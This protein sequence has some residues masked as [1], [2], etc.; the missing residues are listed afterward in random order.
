[1]NNRWLQN[2]STELQNFQNLQIGTRRQEVSLTRRHED[3][4]ARR[5]PRH[6][7]VRS[8]P[9]KS[10]INGFIDWLNLNKVWSLVKVAVAV[11]GLLFGTVSAAYGQIGGAYISKQAVGGTF[12]KSASLRLYIQAS[13]PDGGYVTYQWWRTQDTV[14]QAVVNSYANPLSNA[15]ILDIKT[16]YNAVAVADETEATLTNTTPSIKGNY[17]YWCELGNVT[18]T[19]TGYNASLPALVKIVDRTLPEKLMNGDFAETGDPSS[20]SWPWKITS[21]NYDAAAYAASAYTWSYWNTTAYNGVESWGGKYIALQY[22]TITSGN[23]PADGVTLARAIELSGQ[24]K[25]S[26]YQDVATVPGKIYEWS[27]YHSIS[28]TTLDVMAV[29]IG[30]GINASSDYTSTN[31]YQTKG[32][33]AGLGN[34]KTVGNYTYPYGIDGENTF[35]VDILK[36]AALDNGSSDYSTFFV[37]KDGQTFVTTYNGSQYYISIKKSTSTKYSKASGSYSIPNGQ[38]ISVFGFAAVNGTAQSGNAL[39]HITFASGSGISFDSLMT[40]NGENA[41]S[42][43][44]KAG[45]AYGICEIRGSSV[46]KFSNYTTTYNGSPINPTAIEGNTTDWYYP[47]AAG[48]LKFSDLTPAKSYRIVGVPIGAISGATKLNTNTDPTL[49]LD[50]GY[51]T[52]RLLPSVAIGGGSQMS[53]VMVGAYQEETPPNDWYGRIAIVNTNPQLEYALVEPS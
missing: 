30:K 41:M 50:E 43:T 3:K 47:N 39:A 1:M 17:Y 19:D 40:Y 35:F 37:D 26:V 9:E 28:G 51:Y 22:A 45:F 38:G 5:V 36:K 7:E 16:N 53:Q 44:T 4:K 32:T 48:S 29:I 31:R 8:N 21:S 12:A 25:S 6:C 11:A 23:Q 15:N 20:S 27:L 14:P 52:D 2:Y 10:G 46:L 18:A 42:I 34:K 24:V 49:V 33:I 13:S